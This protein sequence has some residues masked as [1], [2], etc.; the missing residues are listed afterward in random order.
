MHTT[1]TRRMLAAQNRSIV[2]AIIASIGII[3]FL[4]IHTALY[5]ISRLSAPLPLD[6]KHPLSV[7]SNRTACLRD[8]TCLERL[9]S[10]LSRT[11]HGRPWIS[12][13]R[14]EGNSSTHVSSY[15]NHVSGLVLVKVPKSASSTMAGVVLR[16]HH[17]ENCTVRWE[18]RLAREYDW[19]RES[20]RVAPI[21]NPTHR[22]LSSVFFHHVS[23]H[24][25]REPN[26][27]FVINHLNETTPNFILDYTLPKSVYVETEADDVVGRVRGVVEFYNFLFVVE[28]LDDSLV[29]FAWLTG[30]PLSDMLSISSKRSGSWYWNGKKCI[31]LIKP[32][33]TTGV[34]SFLASNEWQDSHLGDH[35]LY[36]AANLSLDRT[37][38]EAMGRSLFEQQLHTY[39]NMR[40]RVDESCQDAIHF[41]CNS[42]GTPQLAKARNS[43]YERDF[44]CGYDCI[45]RVVQQI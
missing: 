7:N 3:S 37:I 24:R 33:L 6:N 45:D 4:Q 13:C 39:M 31:S 28:R 43:C 19:S 25:R 32:F 8:D 17:R 11:W 20:M 41:P 29:V 14:Q 22:A 21:R 18:H 26:D 2:A 9:A 23:F 10:D 12:W 5:R 40:R 44:G 36:K 16:I 30:L 27:Q 15:H 34:A 1:E 35:L 42:G 38:D